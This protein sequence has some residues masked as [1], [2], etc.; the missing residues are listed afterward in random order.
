MSEPHDPPDRLAGSPGILAIAHR[1]DPVA[2]RENTL[3]AIRAALDA[4]ADIVEIDVKTTA[5]GT[6]VVLHDDSLQRLW[7]LD[8]DVR[9]MTAEEVEAVGSSPVDGA[10]PVVEQRIPALD[11]VLR[12]FGGTSAAV[13]VDMDNG[14][15]AAAAL[16]AV[17]RAVGEGTLRPTQVIWCGHLDGMRE[18]RAAD[19]D[20]RIFLSWGEEARGGPPP[21]DLVETL[22]PEAFNPHFAYV[23]HGGRDWCREHHLAL[24]C[25]TVDDE[26]DMA[27]LAQG[28]VDAMISNRIGALIT[29]V[30][31]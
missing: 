29:V 5:D 3:P 9:E 30:R 14:D 10:E 8:R 19:P 2:H 28:G 25:W 11:Q 21:D 12:L 18:V 17:Q 1:G 7:G 6:S 15:Y 24:S 16:A 20:A 13:L 23:E 4:G 31:A 22:R 27:R 26:G